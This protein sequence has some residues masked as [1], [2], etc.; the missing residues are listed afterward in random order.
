[1]VILGDA[2]PGGVHVRV[3]NLGAVSL[4]GRRSRRDAYR[5]VGLCDWEVVNPYPPVSRET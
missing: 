4:C 2:A 1:V 5:D 3:D